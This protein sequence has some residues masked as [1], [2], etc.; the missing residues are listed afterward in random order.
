MFVEHRAVDFD[1]DKQ[2]IPGDGVV[3]GYGK[4][5][6]KLVYVFSQDFTVFVIIS[7]THAEKSAKSWIM[8]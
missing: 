1:M 5:N 4:I 6:G 2:K 8:R 7:E 3:T